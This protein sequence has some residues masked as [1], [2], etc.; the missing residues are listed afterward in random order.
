MGLDVAKSE[1]QL[2]ACEFLLS[3]QCE[4]GGWGESYLSCQDKVLLWGSRAFKPSTA[5]PFPPVAA[6]APF[7][8]VLVAHGC[9]PC[10][11]DD[12]QCISL[13]RHACVCG[14]PCACRP[15]PGPARSRAGVLAA[16]GRQ[17]AGRQHRLGPHCADLRRVPPP[18][19]RAAGRRRPRS[20]ARAGAAGLGSGI[21]AFKD[22]G[23]LWD[24]LGR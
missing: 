11:I 15:V 4:D 24:S 3:K 23:W 19:P 6:M 14:S 8:C 16:G 2:R 22:M 7:K 20:A 10:T 13:H 5:N 18:R 21:T 17:L 1:A 12:C 9:E